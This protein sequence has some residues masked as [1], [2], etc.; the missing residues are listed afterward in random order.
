ML[1]T[2]VLNPLAS[3]AFLLT[4]AAFGAR[5]RRLFL[6]PLP[7]G[8]RLCGDV[9]LGSGGVALLV[10]VLGLSRAW[11]PLVIAGLVVFLVLTGRWQL[12]QWL[13][14]PL[15]WPGLAALLLFPLALAPPFFYDALVYHLSLPWQWYLE[16]GIGP[17][18][19][20]ILAS[21]PP[22]YSCLAAC[23]I[24][25][26]LDRAPALLHLLVFVVAGGGLFS[27]A[28]ALGGSKTLAAICSFCLPLVPLYVLVPALPAAEGFVV[29]PL[30][31]AL[32][33]ALYPRSIPGALVFSGLLLGT[34]LAAKLQ[35]APMVLLLGLVLLWRTKPRPGQVLTASL[36][37]L[38]ASAPWWAKNWILL[39]QPLMPFGWQG[40][41][42]EAAW[43]DSVS[44]IYFAK[45]FQELFRPL[46]AD[47]GPHAGYLLPVV[48]AG[49]LG[50]FPRGDWR[51]R[52]L[53]L[54]LLGGVFA[55]D[56]T[57]A[58][59]RYL[60]P[61][62][63]VLLLWPITVKKRPPGRLA[64]V[65]AF[66]VTASLGFVVTVGQLHRF[67]SF[68]MPFAPVA[69]VYQRLVVNN[70]FPAFAAA[71]R[72]LPPEAKVLFVGEP[73]GFGFPR[74]FSAPSYLDEPELA[75]VLEGTQDVSGVLTWLQ[76]Q[77][78]THILVNWGELERLAPGY[79]AEPWRTPQ[80]RN[81]FLRFVGQ[82]NPPLVQMGGVCLYSLG[83]DGV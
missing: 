6:I 38:L 79:P 51:W 3:I 43:R 80:G 29:A 66:G 14:R 44:T 39:G 11:Q 17:H 55:W 19:E 48:L 36:G 32:G 18:R 74:R 27:I 45:S 78:F 1:L 26:G 8:L 83:R 34:A 31:S 20:S 72:L 69:S 68:T 50:G 30:V 24:P 2:L 81:R 10:V 47:L 41:G 15:I 62:T 64:A 75:R 23:L 22:L 25:W 61:W 82:L 67:A 54:V 59:P 60:A 4:I 56:L 58:V 42:L 49:L 52:S 57:A 21:L 65:L 9:S 77:G 28:R 70:P 53:G 16:G 46:A 7:P 73:R 37:F 71:K 5:L 63:P 13:F 40:P 33:I 35:A 12:R 76:K